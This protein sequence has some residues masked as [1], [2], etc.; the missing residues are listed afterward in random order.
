MLLLLLLMLGLLLSHLHSCSSCFFCLLL[1]RTFRPRCESIF[2]FF[3]GMMN[4]SS[5][6][7]CFGLD[8][9]TAST[10][11]N[12][13][14]ISKIVLVVLRD[15]AA[16][17]ANRASTPLALTPLC[18]FW[19]CLWCCSSGAAF[20]ALHLVLPL[21]LPLVLL[22]VLPVLLLQVLEVLQYVF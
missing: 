4:T 14:R 3:S 19:C 2:S 6:L 11:P 9:C 15:S 20:G 7:P 12:P 22:L 10:S 13:P 21:V 8:T 17:G 5:L 16:Q 18:C 1:L